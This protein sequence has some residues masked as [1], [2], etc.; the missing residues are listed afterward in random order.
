[1]FNLEIHLSSSYCVYNTVLGTENTT[2]NKMDIVTQC[3]HGHTHGVYGL[4][5]DMKYQ[6]KASKIW[7]VVSWFYCKC[8]EGNRKGYGLTSNGCFSQGS[9]WP[10]RRKKIKIRLFSQALLIGMLCRGGI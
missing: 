1:M 6:Q 2:M 9:A 4:M 3:V 7:D 5:E 8:C 10:W